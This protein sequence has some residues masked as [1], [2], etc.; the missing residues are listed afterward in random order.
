MQ[1]IK[2]ENK[3]AQNEGKFTG[4]GRNMQ[5]SFPATFWS[6]SHICLE[7]LGKHC[8]N[9]NLQNIV[10]FLTI[11]TAWKVKIKNQGLILT[12]FEEPFKTFF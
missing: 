11:L 1:V 5:R 12:L 4:S 9:G 2:K 3:L 7:V 8:L 10:C 6:E